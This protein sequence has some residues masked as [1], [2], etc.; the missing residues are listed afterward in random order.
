[1]SACFQ[2]KSDNH[3]SSGTVVLVVVGT[4]I[5]C[6]NSLSHTNRN[7][8]THTHTHTHTQLPNKWAPLRE[9]KWSG[10]Q[11]SHLNRKETPAVY[12]YP[13]NTA[14]TRLQQPSELYNNVTLNVLPQTHDLHW[15]TCIYYIFCVFPPL[16]HTNMLGWVS[17]L[18]LKPWLEA[19]LQHDS[20]YDWTQNQLGHCM[21]HSRSQLNS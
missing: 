10:S 1:M 19:D 20:L 16:F 21:K 9:R 17:V 7:T 8:H 15:L 11:S 12:F 13:E 4:Q 18:I 3:W 5:I 14:K 6:K 2:R